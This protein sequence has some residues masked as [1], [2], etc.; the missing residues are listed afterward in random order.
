MVPV[1]TTGHTPRATGKRCWPQ[2]KNVECLPPETSSM[3]GTYPQYDAGM[4]TGCAPM[5]LPNGFI[6]CATA[7]GRKQRRQGRVSQR[8]RN[9]ASQITSAL[10][11]TLHALGQ[12]A[13]NRVGQFKARAPQPVL[14]LP[15]LSTQNPDGPL[16]HTTPTTTTTARATLQPAS[17]YA[18]RLLVFGTYPVHLGV[19]RPVA[20]LATDEEKDE[21]GHC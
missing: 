6:D 16:G 1:I 10:S 12:L 20:Q 18:S 13:A 2:R 21:H 4:V 11:L 14:H 3:T 5:R 9:G 7:H 19:V 15:I 17:V 8:H